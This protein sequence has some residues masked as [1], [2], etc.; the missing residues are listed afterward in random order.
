MN[1]LVFAAA[2]ASVAGMSTVFAQ[3][4]GTFANSSIAQNFQFINHPP[5]P[6]PAS[7]VAPTGGIRGHRHRQSSTG[8]DST[9]TASAQQ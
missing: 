7:S 9:G 3:S 5:P 2:I 8:S 6:V 1:R 4:S